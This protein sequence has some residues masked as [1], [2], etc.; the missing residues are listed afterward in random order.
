MVFFAA[1]DDGD[2]RIAPD[3]RESVLVISPQA[4]IEAADLPGSPIVVIPRGEWAAMSD[5]YTQLGGENESLRLDNERLQDE[6][7]EAYAKLASLTDPDAMAD[8]VAVRLTEIFARKTGP[9]PKVSE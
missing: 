9:K 1:R 2:G 5:D 7:E 6:L 3:R 8:A 4:L